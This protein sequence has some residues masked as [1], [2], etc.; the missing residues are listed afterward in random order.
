MRLLV[1]GGGTGGHIYPA[2]AIARGFQQR[3]EGAEILYVGTN[4][5][6]EADIVPKAGYA[7]RTV[8]VEGLE[9]K[10]SLKLLTS[11][12]KAVQGLLDTRRILQVFRPQAVVGTGGYVCGPVVLMAALQG[13][14]CLIHEQNAY[15]GITNKMLARFVNQ[16]ALTFGESAKYFPPRAPVKLTG[17]PIRPEVLAAEKEKGRANLGLDKDKF[18]VL[19][20]GGSRGARSI[21]KAMVEVHKW[22]AGRPEVQILHITGQSGYEDTLVQL[23]KE[24]ITLTPKGNS[25]IKPY[26]YNMEDALAAADLIICR[27][28][29]T[30][31]AEVTARGIPAVLI[32][33]PY[34]AENHQ[35]HNARSLENH[36]AAI[37]ILDKDLMG[38][39]LLQ[40]LEALLDAP[41]RLQAMA[42]NSLKLGKPA[43]LDEILDMVDELVK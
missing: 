12:L 8:T 43:A 36:G 37:V 10:L 14:P 16:V 34:A 38:Y 40:T 33:Y 13:I 6:L 11:G 3:H 22:F 17:L 9:R 23:E 41:P 5:G 26:L 25:I 21:N 20:T 29:A 15:P 30:T 1:T 7:F 27:A 4:R 28:G 24:G 31:L 18:L 39:S 42:V 19:V 32:P 35:E 2:L